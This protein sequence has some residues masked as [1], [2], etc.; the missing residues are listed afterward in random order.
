MQ[1][2]VINSTGGP[3]VLQLVQEHPIPK[4]AEGQVL[5]RITSSS[6][7]PVDTQLRAGTLPE[8]V[9]GPNALDGK[10]PKVLGGDLAG[11]VE[12]ADEGSQF[13]KGDAVAAL[14]PYFWHDTQQGT[15]AQYAV[16]EESH[17][18]RVPAA[19]DPAVAG[20][21]P[22]VALTAWQ[23]LQEGKPQ[24]G[25]RVLVLAASGG[26]G[27]M[28]VQLS[29]SLGLTVV[30]V[31]GPSNAAWAKEALGADEVVDYTKQDFAEVY[32]QQPFD[33][34]IDCLPDAL[35]KCLSVLKPT[36]HYSHI[37]NLGTDPAVVQRLR[38]QH[39]AG[40]GPS[41][42]HIF[43]TPN[44]AQL[45]HVLQLMADGKVKLEVAKV[46]PLSEVADAHRQVETGHTRGKVVLQV[47]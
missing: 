47:P 27:H 45:E 12:E 1:A 22:L 8:T 44:G 19:V 13:K 2:V 35:D 9:G 23:A 36:G 40:K 15:Y 17:L 6:V 28:A 38:Q 24:S 34:A 31:A 32:R 10:Y 26:V 3:E 16:A 5:V 43:V 18:A 30:A 21:L 29:K 33:I 11:T 42:S 25:Q 46:F 14:T 41:I 4:R 7:N 20:G 37:Q 39:E